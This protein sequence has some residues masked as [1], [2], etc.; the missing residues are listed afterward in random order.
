MMQEDDSGKVLYISLN[1]RFRMMGPL[2]DF[3]ELVSGQIH[4]QDLSFVRGPAS[5]IMAPS[6]GR[7]GFAGSAQICHVTLDGNDTGREDKGNVFV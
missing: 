5:H 1:G 2:F 4:I 3:R 6:P 7:N